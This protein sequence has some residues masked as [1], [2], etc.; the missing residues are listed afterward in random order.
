VPPPPPQGLPQLT[1]QAAVPSGNSFGV[2]NALGVSGDGNVYGMAAGGLDEVSRATDVHAAAGEHAHSAEVAPP[3]CPLLQPGVSGAQREEVSDTTRVHVGITASSAS[4]VA[5]SSSA[6]PPVFDPPSG[7]SCVAEGTA[8]RALSATS[9][10]ARAT[11]SPPPPTLQ[12]LPRG[13]KRRGTASAHHA[14]QRKL[15]RRVGA[16]QVLAAGDEGEDF[17]APLLRPTPVLEQLS[18]QEANSDV[19]ALD[20]AVLFEELGLLAQQQADVTELL[21]DALAEESS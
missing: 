21:Q 20:T 3:A 16:S 15:G 13:S 19:L 8:P 9:V 14:G 1:L 10:A 18:G 4:D 5:G 6:L 7:V 2:R 11:P 12:P 17:R